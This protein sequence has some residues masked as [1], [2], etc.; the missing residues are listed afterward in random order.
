MHRSNGPTLS[1]PEYSYIALKM[2]HIVSR[3][4]VYDTR[5]RPSA[6]ASMDWTPT[7]RH[8]PKDLS[9]SSDRECV[10]E[11]VL[12]YLIDPSLGKLQMEMSRYL[13]L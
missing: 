13:I 6:A 7:Q 10:E 5:V 3:L 11:L 8:C 9:A 2:L 4:F 1:T 12:H